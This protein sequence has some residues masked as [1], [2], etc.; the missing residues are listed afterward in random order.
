MQ[1]SV[2]GVRRSNSGNTLYEAL[3]YNESFTQNTC[4]MDSVACSKLSYEKTAKVTHYLQSYFYF[5]TICQISIFSVIRK[6]V[7]QNHRLSPRALLCL[8]LWC[9][10]QIKSEAAGRYLLFG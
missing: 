7:R 3:T 6:S 5:L 10:L 1:S 9:P 2:S 8:F 4:V